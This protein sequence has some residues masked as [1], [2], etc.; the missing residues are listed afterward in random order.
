MYGQITL[1]RRSSPFPRFGAVIVAVVDD[2][3][4]VCFVGVM[5]WLVNIASS[6]CGGVAKSFSEE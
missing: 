4:G 2:I 5:L 6:G 1:P 3:G